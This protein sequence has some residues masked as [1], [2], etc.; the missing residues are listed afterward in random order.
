MSG[1]LEF[2]DTADFTIMA[3][4]EHFMATDIEW[5]PTGRYVV[6]GISW[7]MHKVD[8]AFWLWTFQGRLLRKFDLERFCQLLWRPRPPS[9]LSEEKIKEIK[10]N[11]K[12]YSGQFDIKDRMT[13]SK[14]SKEIVEKR[15]NLME[16]FRSMRQ[17]RIDEFNNRKKTR[18]ELRSGIDTDEL[19]AEHGNLEEEVVEFLVKE[20]VIVLEEE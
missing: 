19:D 4:N 17:K 2:I 9:L 15:R 20:E 5:D 3:Q 18:L 7:W 10:K 6:S 14:A 1:S 8:N 16:E 13:L 12:K 11:L